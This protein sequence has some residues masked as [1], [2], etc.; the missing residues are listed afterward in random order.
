M[1]VL[2]KPHHLLLPLHDRVVLLRLC[3][4]GWSPLGAGGGGIQYRGK[5]RG[6]ED[7]GGERERMVYTVVKV[8]LVADLLTFRATSSRG[9]TDDDREGQHE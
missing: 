5:Q 2:K 9:C 6:C 4:K 1:A 7:D 8:D 3:R